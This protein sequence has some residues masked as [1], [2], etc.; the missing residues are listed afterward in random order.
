MD[1][2]SS[3]NGFKSY[4]QLEK[5]LSENSV[6]A[7][8]RDISKILQYLE[9]QKKL[10]SPVDLDLG[11]FQ[12]FLQWAN[13]LG[14]TNR[15]Q[16]RTISGIKAFYKYLLLED[17]IQNDPTELLEAPKV[18][19]KLPEVLTIEEINLLFDA[20]DQSKPEG[21]RNRTMLETMY[22]SGLRVSELINLMKTDVYSSEG[23]L[24][25]TG[26]GDKERLVPIGGVALKQIEIYSNDIRNHVEIKKEHLDILFLNR[27]GSKLSRV[28]I[29][30]II[31]QLAEKIGLKK[32]ISPHTFRHS[33]ATHLIEG[34]A[35]LRA[36]QEMLG[37][38][39][40]TT[41]EIYTHLDREFLR[42]EIIRFHPRS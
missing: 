40:I 41:T 22:G 27:R 3:I 42:S 29:F 35:D 9:S 20:I 5:S 19:L 24:K 8:V 21:V 4:L 26:K 16:A 38:E 7:Y 14:M 1:W 12:S 25:V 15:T 39:S 33:F 18:G 2:K 11:T 37:Q 10:L 30:K 6:A 23:F 28:M 32:N 13:E 31:K 34:G 36:I 17:L